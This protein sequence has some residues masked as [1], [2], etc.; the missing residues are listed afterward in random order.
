MPIVPID[1]Q[2]A[3]ENVSLLVYGYTGVGKTHFA[4]T[5]P[6]NLFLDLEDGYR[7]L[8]NLPFDGKVYRISDASDLR[9]ALKPFISEDEKIVSE[10]ENR[11]G[12]RPKTLTI[13]TLTR[14][15]HHSMISIL[16]SREMKAGRDE[17]VL[18]IR[19]WGKL[20]VQ[21]YRIMKLLPN[22]KMDV[23]CLAQAREFEDPV[24]GVRK[25]MPNLVGQW[26]DQVGAYFDIVAFLEVR[27]IEGRLVRR[28]HLSP[29]H[30]FLTKSRFTGLPDY[31]DNPTFN[32][33][34]EL[35]KRKEVK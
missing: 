33:L 16:D 13:D 17:D 11:L 15:Q 21:M 22:H 34:K 8:L 3:T 7:T 18:E 29:S 19:E 31:L 10:L 30:R 12:F 14:L 2:K 25:W 23:V 4:G 35:I 32:Q 28:L 26:G 24:T 1:L 5:A 6:A 9:D 27:E 20:L